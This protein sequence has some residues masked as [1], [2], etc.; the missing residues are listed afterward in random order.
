MKKSIV[1]NFVALAV[2]VAFLFLFAG[3]TAHA[4]MKVGVFKS[5]QSAEKAMVGK[6]DKVFYP[7]KD[8]QSL[9]DAMRQSPGMNL[10]EARAFDKNHEGQSYLVMWEESGTGNG[11]S[12]KKTVTEEKV[13]EK[14][15]YVEKP[16]PA[17]EPPA[18]V[19]QEVRRPQKKGFFGQLFGSILTINVIPVVQPTV[20]G[21]RYEESYGEDDCVP[22][23]VPQRRVYYNEPTYCLPVVRHRVYYNE[24]DCRPERTTY[25]PPPRTYCPPSY[26]GGHSGG[27]GRNTNTNVVNNE[28]HVQVPRQVP[29]TRSS[30]GPTFARGDT[31]RDPAGPTRSS[32]SSS[33][34][35]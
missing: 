12:G 26:R 7:S 33:H 32:G 3:L 35:R 14:V 29:S 17:P 6:K 22:D 27:G 18:E 10:V 4:E 5:L 2:V 21:E 23:F 8:G 16:A 11:G 1:A 20:V 13:K 34:H 19:V 30:S 24:P 31:T 28:V 9:S 25:C 15:R